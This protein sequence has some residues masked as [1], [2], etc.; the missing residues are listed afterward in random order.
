MPPILNLKKTINLP[1]TDFPMRAGLPRNEPRW[2]RFW[3]EM[4]L[5]GELRRLRA[6]APRFILHDGPPYANGNIH[7]G[8]ALNKILKDI[9]VKSQSLMGRDAPFIP[10]WDCHGLPIENRV[11]RERKRQQAD[12][13]PLEIRS[14]CRRYAEQFIKVQ[15]EEFKRLGILW[16]WRVDKAEEEAGE[17]NRTAIYRTI[18]HEYEAAVIRELA[19]FF[20]AGSIYH[21]RKPVHWCTSCRTALAEAEVEYAERTDPSVYVAFPL[22]NLD[23]RLPALAGIKVEAVIWTT[24]P[25]TLPANR[26]LCLH[27]DFVYAVVRTGGRHFLVAR[28]LLTETAKKCGWQDV[29]TVAT[30]T[31]RELVGEG[32][33]WCGRADPPLVAHSPYQEATQGPDSF[34]ILGDHVTLE[35]GTGIVHTA[36]GHGADDYYVSARYDI[37]PWVPVDDDGCFIG[38]MVPPYAGRNVFDANADIVT[39]L[40]AA[41]LLLAVEDHAHDYPHCWRCH[42]PIVFRATPQWF[43]SMDHDDLRERAVAAIHA[44]SW[45]PSYGEDR[46]ATMVSGRPDW[47][48][49]R[50]RTWGVPIPILACSACSSQDHLVFINQPE[51]FS[52]VADLFARAGSDAWFGRAGPGDRVTAYPDEAAALAR[53]LPAG[54][55]CPDCG[56]RENLARRFE[57]VDVWFESGASHSAVLSRQG[58]SWP[59]DLYLEGHDQYRGWFH[60]SL[61]VAVNG[62]DG[63]APY[64]RVVTHGFT[65]DSDG[66]KMSK[67]RGN[68]VSPME[69]VADKGADILRLWASMVNFLED[70]SFSQESLSRQSDAYRKIRNTFRFILGNLHDFDPDAD[71][72]PV[73]DMDAL[74]RHVLQRFDQLRT[75]VLQAYEKT[76]LHVVAHS[77]YQFCGVTLSS[78]YLDI[79]KDRLYTH[80]PVSPARRSAQT[81]L[82]LMG[83]G[84]C[85]LVAPI[86][87]FTAEEVWQQMPRRAGQKNSVHLET[88]P[89]ATG[90]GSEDASLWKAVHDLRDKVFRQLELARSSKIIRSGLDAMVTFSWEG[91]LPG[92]RQEYGL[93]WPEF[94]TRLGNRLAEMFIVS[95]VDLTAG[96]QSKGET[97]I[98][99]PLAGL[100]IAVARHPG[101][102]CPRCWN[103]VTELG[104]DTHFPDVCG[105]CAPRLSAGLGDGAWP[106]SAGDG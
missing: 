58:L 35:Q 65:L 29:E 30:V 12:L 34:L 104:V 19:R 49:S 88:F 15:R 28:D 10:G 17:A 91:N 77:L 51:F 54:I 70:M 22:E 82:W 79:I 20:A 83:S 41:G 53:L 37:A 5:Y 89:D 18:D 27:P 60:S 94:T 71:L 32:D 47:C 6:G 80:A 66:R 45:R 24:T 40:R 102:K 103:Y 81:A 52:H 7:L 74:D 87:S 3:E 9:L 84:L 63:R 78:F 25:W 33:A 86:L 67:S 75:R 59:A 85:R 55:S 69:I 98:D 39:E 48:I 68:T 11:E 105:R 97:V 99:G 14:R 73:A 31:G 23:R 92:F 62:H 21:G 36:P 46:I 2:L 93:E 95:Q 50:Q 101:V 4:D 90:A 57:I 16:D 8:Q 42:H 96:G 38:A 72:V 61:L 13:T 1:R 26:A 106:D 56:R 100:T 43:I 64:R 76:E 44:T